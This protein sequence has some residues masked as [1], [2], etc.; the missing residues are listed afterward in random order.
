MEEDC[1]TDDAQGQQR[2]TCVY[3]PLVAKQANEQQRRGK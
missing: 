1:A 2:A 3:E